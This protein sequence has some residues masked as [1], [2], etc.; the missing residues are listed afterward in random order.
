MKNQT[1]I[2]R[3]GA[4]ALRRMVLDGLLHAGG[5]ELRVLENGA[6][7]LNGGAA[8]LEILDVRAYT[9]MARGGLG[10]AEAYMKRWWCSPDLA[11]V[12]R[13]LARNIEN[14]NKM[15]TLRSPWA[16]KMKAVAAAAREAV[17]PRAQAR[18]HVS[19]HYDLDPRLFSLFL[20]D[21]MAYSC[22]VYPQHG[23]SLEAAQE[24]KLEMICNKLDLREG[25]SFLDLG[26]GW[27][28]L[29]LYAARTRGCKTTALTLSQKQCD[30]LRERARR[31]GLDGKIRPLCADY[32]DA[33][34]EKFDKIASVEMIEAVGARR[35]GE[36]FR[37]FAELLAPHGT[38]VVQA[39]LIPEER[40]A[41]AALD[42][43]FISVYIFPGGALPSEE[44]VRAESSAAGLKM[45]GAQKIG[46]HYAAT[47]AEWRRRFDGNRARVEQ[48][49]F[50]E[51]FRRMWEYYFCYCEGGFAAG[52][53]DNAQFVFSR[54]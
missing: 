23:A 45:I 34:K 53:L 27:G 21:A 41:A 17:F 6:A 11:A 36:Y 43:D 30:F 47:L 14:A 46:E 9:A 19:A 37:R 22:A 40:R 5:G 39:I 29:S 42:P 10:A 3:G 16:R 7:V 2:P 20:D 28:A 18:R 26:C 25:D 38:G 33:P 32:R 51:S 8:Q 12:M 35:F 15:E 24:N 49:G 13:L 1:V 4:G 48:M 31:E 50:G 52:A 44:S 54:E